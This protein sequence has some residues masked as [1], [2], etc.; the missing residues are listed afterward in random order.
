[1]V[2][3]FLLAG[4]ADENASGPKE[5]ITS[6]TIRISVDESFKPVIDSQIKVFEAQHSQAKIIVD[7]KPEAEC[8]RDLTNDSIR[9]VIVTR[10]L[11]PAEEKL[12]IDK[13][14]FKP[15]YGRLAIDAVAVIVNNKS[16]DTLFTMQD[17]K[18]MV[19]G[20]SS[21]KYKVLLDG[22]TATSTVRYVR[23][24]LLKGEN[25][26]KNVVAAANS[27]AVI[28]YVSEHNDAIGMIGVSWIGNRQDSAQ[29]SFL[30]KVKIAEIECRGCT[31][32]YVQ[33]VQGNI[34]LGRYPMVR[35]LYYILKEN[36]KGVGSGFTNFLIYEKGQL[37]FKRA[38]LLPVRM[39]FDVRSINIT[40]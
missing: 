37:I 2:S 36:F 7:Y 28:D 27:K 12:M 33:P 10:G 34:A 20:I 4:C 32:T 1:V 24:S 35:P 39:Q 38:Y 18:S 26:S 23:D 22:T 13:Y 29:L 9:M 40:E 21:R 6:G 3:L 11:T 17:I 31:G 8:L 25:L 19:K 15:K 14:E 16:E 5:T 30:E